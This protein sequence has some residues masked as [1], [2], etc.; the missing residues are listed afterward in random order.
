[1]VASASEGDGATLLSAAGHSNGG[2]LDAAVAR[3]RDKLKKLKELPE[4]VHELVAGGFDACVAKLQDELAT[5][6]SARRAANPPKQQLE[7]A[8]AY[9]KRMEKKLAEA[10]VV[11]QA[12]EAELVELNK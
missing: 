8:E 10:R 12:R 1:M 7:S 11:L 9:Q 2:E 6:Q 5:A 3:A 4:E